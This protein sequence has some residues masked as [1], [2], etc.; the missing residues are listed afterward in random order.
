M[1]ETYDEYHRTGVVRL[2]FSLVFSYTH[3]ALSICYCGGSMVA[4]CLC[5]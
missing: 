3:E 5:Q 4:W 2:A 1:L